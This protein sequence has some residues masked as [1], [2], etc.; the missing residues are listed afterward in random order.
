[1]SHAPAIAAAV[2]LV[3]LAREAAPEQQEAAAAA[4]LSALVAAG[5]ASAAD[6]LAVDEWEDGGVWVGGAE[7]GSVLFA[8]ED[9][10]VETIGDYP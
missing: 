6:P 1:M 10:V 4:L 8:R 2:A 9:G 5:V 7:D 3:L